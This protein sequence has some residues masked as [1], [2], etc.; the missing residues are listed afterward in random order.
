MPR[1]AAVQ[2]SDSQLGFKPSNAPPLD[3]SVSQFVAPSIIQHYQQTA[4]QAGIYSSGL[5]VRVARAEPAKRTRHAAAMGGP[6]HM[7]GAVVANLDALQ[8]PAATAGSSTPSVYAN[9][10]GLPPTAVVLFPGD[11][12]SLNAEGRA[13][14]RN[15]VEK[16]KAAGEQGYIRVVGHSS[17][18]TPNMSPERHQQVVFTKSQERAN[19]VAQEI[20]REGVPASKVLVEAVGDTQPIYYESMPKGEDGNRRAEIFLQS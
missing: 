16:F 18:R 4:S 5:P 13:L 3:P 17:S 14:V 7:S 19:A 12:V 2:P 15:A 9:A 11:T 1:V 20:I 10:Q 8:Q 6:E